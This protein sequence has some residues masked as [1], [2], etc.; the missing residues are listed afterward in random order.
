MSVTQ[1]TPAKK[2]RSKGGKLPEYS[3]SIKRACVALRLRLGIPYADIEKLTGI[4]KS[5]VAAWL[6]RLEPEERTE[7]QEKG[8]ITELLAIGRQYVTLRLSE[9][10]QLAIGTQQAILKEIQHRITDHPELIKDYDLTQMLRQAVVAAGTAFDKVSIG[11]GFV[12]RVEGEGKRWQINFRITTPNQPELEA[13]PA[14]GQ[15][16]APQQKL[17]VLHE[18]DASVVK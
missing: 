3:A 16:A 4:P 15:L 6:H 10:S 2:A 13:P 9:T 14:R 5:T 17:P 7:I 1:T 12:Q 8:E 11:G 18:A